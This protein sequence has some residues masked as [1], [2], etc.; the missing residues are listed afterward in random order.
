[1][2]HL[3][4]PDNILAVLGVSAL[5]SIFSIVFSS[6]SLMALGAFLAGLAGAMI[7]SRN[8]VYVGSRFRFTGVLSA[9]TLLATGLGTVIAYTSFETAEEWSFYLN[10][11]GILDSSTVATAQLA[12]DLFCLC[13]FLL[14]LFAR[15][16]ALTKQISST[17]SWEPTLDSK[18]LLK[19]ANLPRN[20]RLTFLLLWSGFLVSLYQL[21]LL[22]TGKFGFLWQG[23]TNRKEGGLKFVNP[24]MELLLVVVPPIIFILGFLLLKLKEFESDKLAIFLYCSIAIVQLMWFITAASRGQFAFNTLVFLFGVRIYILGQSI[25]FNKRNIFK[26]AIVTA[27]IIF[28]A[29]AGIQFTSFMR[30]LANE[31]VNFTS[32][33][34]TGKFSYLAQELVNYYSGKYSTLDSGEFESKLSQNLSTRPFV[35]SGFAILLERLADEPVLLGEDLWS[36]FLQSIPGFLF[37]GKYSLLTQESLYRARLDISEAELSDLADSYY[38]SAFI[39]FSWL[40][41]FI[42]PVVIYLLFILTL[43]ITLKSSSM[44]LHVLATGSLFTLCLRGGESSMIGF[45]VN[46]RDLLI[47]VIV[48]TLCR[49]WFYRKSKS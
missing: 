48:I 20:T 13:L 23:V 6:N 30:F 16:R 47:F 26:I 39:D 3:T 21:Y 18:L 49:F 2:L 11:K 40:G 24:E 34:L 4:K 25:K 35:L 1:M 27:S 29:Y 9:S 37:P 44:L 42:Y 12:V 8:F 38:L 7:L 5:I 14:G 33:S 22:Y 10:R 17:S 41:L 15:R 32:Y 31:G 45:F 46:L 36:S 28:I 43:R 19:I